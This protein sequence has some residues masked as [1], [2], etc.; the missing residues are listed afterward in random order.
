M[1]ALIV[2]SLFLFCIACVCVI[3]HSVYKFLVWCYWIWYNKTHNKR[4]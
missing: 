4:P 3:A 2:W 1:A